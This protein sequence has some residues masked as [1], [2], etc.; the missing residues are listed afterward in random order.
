MITAPLVIAAEALEGAAADNG[1]GHDHGDGWASGE[2]LPRQLYNIAVHVVGAIGFALLLL[3]VN[4]LA[5]GLRDGRHGVLWGLAGFTNVTLAPALA[6]L[7]LGFAVRVLVVGLVL[8][9]AWRHPWLLARE[10]VQT[11]TGRGVC[12]RKLRCRRARRAPCMWWRAA[13]SAS[14]PSL[15]QI[16]ATMARCSASAAAGRSGT[17]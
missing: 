9:R 12:S 15:A 5:G 16:A 11:S 1:Y 17:A 3:V 10:V 2:G 4:K 14:A 8:G 7:H 6:A 13:A